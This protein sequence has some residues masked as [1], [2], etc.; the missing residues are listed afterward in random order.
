MMTRTSARRLRARRHPHEQ[1]RY[2]LGHRRGSGRITPSASSGSTA[3]IRRSTSSTARRASS[4]R[5][6]TASTPATTC[7]ACSSRTTNPRRGDACCRSGPQPYVMV[8][9]EADGPIPGDYSMISLG[10]I[11]VEPS[12]DR[13]FSA[14]LKPISEK[15]VPEAL[16]VSGFT[17]EQTM[18]VPRSEAA[19]CER[20]RRG[21]ASSAAVSR[22]SSPTTTAS[23]GSSCAGTST[24]SLGKNP[25]GFSSQNLGSLYKGLVKDMSRRSSTCAR[26]S[27]RTIRSTTR[28][29]T[30]KR[31]C[32]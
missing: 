6:S 14:Q 15:W 24:T 12:L 31:C 29:A 8:D 23:T 9:I 13:E 10:A 3:S 20:S 30:P 1:R 4:I 21:S 26:R 17:R 19:R 28:A 5:C 7:G 11:V 27:T 32:T 22:C 18:D 25:F 2:R 16:A